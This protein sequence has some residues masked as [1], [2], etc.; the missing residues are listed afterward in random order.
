GCAVGRVGV[1]PTGEA[2]HFRSSSQHPGGKQGQGASTDGSSLLKASR[3]VERA[4][5]HRQPR[6][7]GSSCTRYLL[8]PAKSGRA[9][10][11]RKLGYKAVADGTRRKYGGAE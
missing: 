4:A 11:V 6:S 2:S 9:T 8:R 3:Y 7:A 10:P 5:R 1:K